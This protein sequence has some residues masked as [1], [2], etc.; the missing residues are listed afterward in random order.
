MHI[1]IDGTHWNNVRGYGRYARGLITALL[2]EPRGHVY[3]LFVDAH[4]RET[5]TLPTN[6]EIMTV[7]TRRAQAEAA[8]G[9]RSIPD[10]LTMGAKV[11]RTPL[12]VMFYPSLY[13]YF[14]VMTNA[15]KLVG[16]HDVIAEKYPALIF[17]RGKGQFQWMLKSMVARLQADYLLTVSEYAK[18]EIVSLFKWSPEKI[19]VVGEAP[20]A[21]FHPISDQAE[22]RAARQ[23]IGLT[24]DAR[25]LV[26][27]G[28]INPHKN[29]IALVRAFVDVSARD[30]ARDLHLVLIGPQSSDLFTHGFS[31]VRGE[32]ERLNAMERIHFT[33]YL[34][35][36]EVALLLNGALALVLPSLEEGYGLPGIEAAACGIP[37]IATRNSALPDVLQGGGIFVDPRA[38]DA[39]RDAII[40]LITDPVLRDQFAKT[41]LERAQALTWGNAADQFRKAVS[42]LK[43]GRTPAQP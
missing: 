36:E 22:I 6:A 42:Q 32:V 24:D 8:D 33:D 27:L 12:D 3:T 41:A 20:D 4:T 40:A 1:G 18:R 29:V 15:I 14:P 5:S 23:S 35:D 19:V 37:V 38:P 31:A 13:T 39:L 26:Y 2:N 43:R 28:G 25:Y 30:D 9:A 17:P 10:M 16:I 34:A 7:N 21:V 11:S